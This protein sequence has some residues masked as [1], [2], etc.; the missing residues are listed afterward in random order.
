[1]NI[2]LLQELDIFATQQATSSS[3]PDRPPLHSCQ[4][5]VI[6]QTSSHPQPNSQPK[7]PSQH[8][9]L[10]QHGKSGSAL[11][12]H[13]QQ[14]GFQYCV[15]TQDGGIQDDTH[16]QHQSSAFQQAPV[17]TDRPP[18]QQQPNQLHSAGVRLV[19]Q[20]NSQRHEARLLT[21]SLGPGEQLQSGLGTRDHSRRIGYQSAPSVGQ[22]AGAAKH[23]SKEQ[24]HNEV[25]LANLSTV[26]PTA[27]RAQN[28]LQPRTHEDLIQMLK[29]ALRGSGVW[30]DTTVCHM[31]MHHCMS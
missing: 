26:R 6:H 23:D 19:D 7:S 22:D 20:H 2:M 11:L 27:G 25:Q 9:D 18:L 14:Q 4:N 8:V 16:D 5:T 10:Q 21:S 15:P 17:R 29:G 12:Q 3:Q 13:P 1:M 30:D 31:H 28:A 24:Q